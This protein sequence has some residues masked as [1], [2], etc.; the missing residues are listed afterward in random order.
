MN[1]SKIKQPVYECIS[2]K[3]PVY[4]FISNKQPVYADI[5]ISELRDESN[6]C[7]IINGC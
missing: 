4:A 2:N 5:H 3:Q 7:F 1:L 6:R